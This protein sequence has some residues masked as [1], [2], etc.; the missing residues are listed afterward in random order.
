[1]EFQLNRFEI[2][3][4]ESDASVAGIVFEIETSDK[5]ILFSEVLNT[6]RSEDK[7]MLLAIEK[8]M[9]SKV[10]DKLWWNG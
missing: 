8:F 9:R 5:V 4:L 1:M 6:N 2:K 3:G 10:G 7:E